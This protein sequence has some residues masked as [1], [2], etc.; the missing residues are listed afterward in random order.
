M[1]QKIA[2]FDSFGALAAF[3]D[4]E[5]SPLPEG[6]QGVEITDDAWQALL[7]AQGAGKVLRLGADGQ[8]EA[9]D[10]PPPPPPTAAQVLQTRDL[11]LAEAT[12]RI[13]PLQ[14]AVDIEEATAAEV[15]L[16]KKWKQYRVALSRVELQVGFPAGVDW[17]VAPI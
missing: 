16:L 1:G 4:S 7:G 17:P 9:V 5:D 8:P 10:P 15:A 14:D 12:V 2:V 6:A 3:Y 11:L 13:A